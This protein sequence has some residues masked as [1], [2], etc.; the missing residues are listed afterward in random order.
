MEATQM[1]INRWMDKKDVV[2]MYNEIIAIKNN[3]I[4]PFATVGMDLENIM[5]S[6]IS[7]MEKN[8]YYVL[9]LICS[10]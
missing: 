1:S 2:Y 7:Q 4:L 3:E 5:L 9:S 8:K 6:E 10:I